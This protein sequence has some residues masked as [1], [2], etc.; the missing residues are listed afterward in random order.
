MNRFILDYFNLF[1]QMY[2]LINLI[3]HCIVC[4]GRTR[5]FSISAA[6]TQNAATI[7][8]FSTNELLV[9]YKKKKKSINTS[10]K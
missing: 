9:W 10:K 8:K 4:L 3:D 2:V 7:L 5:A 1:Q 6:K